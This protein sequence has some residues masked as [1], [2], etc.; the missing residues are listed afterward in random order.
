MKVI[1]LEDVRK[2]GKKG[3][4]LEVSDGFA[5][6]V[7]FRKKQAV[8]AT[9]KSINDIELKQQ[10]EEKRKK[11]E[12]ADAKQLAKEIGD[13]EITVSMKIGKGGKVF[14]SISSKEI[15]NETKKQL[16][17]DLDKKKIVLKE[18]IKSLGV[19]I[20]ELKLHADVVAKLKV[21]VVEE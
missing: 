1:L 19:H 8:E 13:M 10:N 2:V 5:R 4:L 17:L 11:E 18:A 7:L 6:N 20:V 16:N 14:G 9:K 15:A 12:L 21:K 3:D